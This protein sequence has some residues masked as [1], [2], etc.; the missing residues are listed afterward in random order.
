MVGVPKSK[1]CLWCFQQSIKVRIGPFLRARTM[2]E[3]K[4]S[5]T[6]NDRPVLNVEEVDGPVLVA[7]DG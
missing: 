6:K 1:G 3:L 4:C 2:T 7:L 5:A